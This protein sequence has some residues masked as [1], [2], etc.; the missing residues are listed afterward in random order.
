MEEIERVVAEDTILKVDGNEKSSITWDFW[1]VKTLMHGTKIDKSHLRNIQHVFHADTDRRDKA[2][3]FG[4]T[5]IWIS[6][7]IKIKMFSLEVSDYP[8]TDAREKANDFFWSLL[9]YMYCVFEWVSD[10]GNR[11]GGGWTLKVWIPSKIERNSVY[12]NNW[13]VT[14]PTHESKEKCCYLK[15][16]WKRKVFDGENGSRNYTFS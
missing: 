14:N 12:S 15:H 3:I 7:K 11:T 13:S 5:W 16:P 6:I 9:V 2:R 1:T 8:D 10:G 4:E